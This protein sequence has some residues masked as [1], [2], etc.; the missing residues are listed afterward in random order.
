MRE[1]T[2]EL[3]A[4]SGMIQAF[5]YLDATFIPVKCLLKNS[6]DFLSSTIP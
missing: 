3:E 2:C 5:K 6:Q 4:K 1:T